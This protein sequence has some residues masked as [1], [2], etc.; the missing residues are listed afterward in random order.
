MTYPG[1]N[2]IDTPH[3]AASRSIVIAAEPQKVWPWLVQMG[4]GRGGF[5]SYTF[6][7]NLIGCKMK[8]AD[9][10]HPE[11]QAL[12]VGDKVSIHPKANPLHVALLKANEHL[13]FSQ[14]RPVPWTWA[15]CLE[16]AGDGSCKLVVRTRAKVDNWIGRWLAKP[17]VWVGHGLMERK[18]L[19]G[20][21]RRAESR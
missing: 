18:M 15:F 16:E 5:Y 12:K 21:K 4:Q 7:E 20:I 17:A 2:L 8:N 10:I 14:T 3:L 1:D 6:L 9:Q 13:V 19:Q 11:W